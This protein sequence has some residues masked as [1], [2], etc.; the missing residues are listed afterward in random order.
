MSVALPL[1]RR[2]RSPGRAP[3]LFVGAALLLELLLAGSVVSDRLKP[4][5]MLFI[6]VIGFV[7]IV[8]WPLLGMG[9]VVLL[10]ATF[11]PSDYL[12]IQVGGFAFGYHEL[13]L[14][15]VLAAS[16][17][18]PR[19][20][21][22]GGAAGGLLAA[23]LGI[24]L[25]AT[26]LAISSGH[27]AFSDAVAWGRMFALLT[28]FYA[29]VRLFPD[30]ESLGRLMRVTVAAAGASGFIALAIAFGVNLDSVL[31]EAATYY[32]NTDLG[33]GGIPRIRLPAVALAYPL[34]LYALLHIPRSRG[35]A[36]LAWTLAVVGMGANLVLSLNRN[37]W[38][39][40]LLGLAVLMFLGGMRVR[41]PVWIG[42]LALVGAIAIV[43]IAGVQVDRGPL[44]GFAE[45]GQTLFSPQK[46]T[47]ENSL[48]DRGKETEQAWRTI[49]QHPVIGIGPGAE[50]GVYFDELQPGGMGYKRT[51]QLF[52][53][54][55]YLYLL[56]I[57]GIPGLLAFL[58][59]LTASV[60][61]A[62]HYL[63]DIDVATWAVG[64]G[65][66]ALSAVVMISIA[67]ASSALAIGLLC[68]AIVAAT[69]RTYADD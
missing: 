59:F 3:L 2:P 40:L 48:Q 24:L 58:G 23:F 14:G 63:W 4:L 32:V 47:S 69:S 61:R 51:H 13:A 35:F 1:R 22:W 41:R 29:V 56:L 34:F 16:V 55:Q 11:L 17:V 42:V 67:D 12:Q 46:T 37:M 30:R 26:L 52:L 33:L 62:W 36:R 57:C 28:V 53:H 31:G 27:L 45:R 6:A 60:G 54:N 7:A 66:I 19:A 10:T 8:R 68:G 43:A 15:G 38:I 20:K 50:F 25:L 18:A 64:V 44:A 5:L 49:K 65:M 39:G 21:T 9:L